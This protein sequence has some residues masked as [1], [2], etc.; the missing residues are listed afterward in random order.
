MDAKLDLTRTYLH[1]DHG[2]AE[3]MTVDETFWDRVI[4]GALP[5]PGWLV[6]M[7]EFPGAGEGDTAGDSEMH[8]NGDELHVCVS[9]SMS[10]VLEHDGGT[11]VVDFPAGQ[12]CLIPRGVWHRLVAKEPSRIL[13]LTFGEGT[14]HRSAGG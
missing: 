12:S 5:L 1:L 7:F 13:S 11:Q 8:P 3:A 9:G 10:A 2:R 6:A 14:E 4:S